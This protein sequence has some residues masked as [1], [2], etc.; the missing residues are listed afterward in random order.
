MAFRC[1]WRIFKVRRNHIRKQAE[2]SS[3]VV[4]IRDGTPRAPFTLGAPRRRRQSA[5]SFLGQPPGT[6]DIIT[7]GNGKWLSVVL[8]AT[9]KV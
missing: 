2:K 4:T 9:E 3:I 8:G 5:D 6:G 1:R 7:T